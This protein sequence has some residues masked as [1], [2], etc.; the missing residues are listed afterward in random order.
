MLLLFHHSS[1]AG[2][3]IKLTPIYDKGKRAGCFFGVFL[4]L[5]LFVLLLKFVLLA[6]LVLLMTRGS[7][8]SVCVIVTAIVLLFLLLCHCY[9]Y[10]IRR[11]LIGLAPIHDKGERGECLFC[12]LSAGALLLSVT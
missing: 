6:L 11:L 8:E 2:L 1:D 9:C 12:Q 5:L 4:I 10:F 3:L 7:Q